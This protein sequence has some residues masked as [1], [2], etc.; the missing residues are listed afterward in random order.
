M[1]LRLNKEQQKELF[2]DLTKDEIKRIVR[3]QIDGVLQEEV[4]RL[5]KAKINNEISCVDINNTLREEIRRV[6][7]QKYHEQITE[8]LTKENIKEAL[9]KTITLDSKSS[10]IFKQLE[11]MMV[12][13]IRNELSDVLRKIPSLVEKEED[14][15]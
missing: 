14:K 5:I 1:V 2:E 15:K 13:N 10:D 9:S 6:L 8:F 7:T 3:E 4:K 12:K 11:E